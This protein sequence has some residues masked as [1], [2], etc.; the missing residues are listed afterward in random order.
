MPLRH[1]PTI[2]TPI[3]PAD[4]EILR[5][6]LFMIPLSAGRALALGLKLRRPDRARL[7]QVNPKSRRSLQKP[8]NR[9][10][11]TEGVQHRG[12]VELLRVAFR[13]LALASAFAANAIAQ[14]WPAHPIRI[15]ATRPPGGSR[16]AAPRSGTGGRGPAGRGGGQPGFRSGQRPGGG[17]RKRSR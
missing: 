4:F 2:M 12:R 11:N 5:K 9:L 10:T 8:D 17:G 6:F 13:A 3:T 14:P 15:V 1:K 16:C 7:T